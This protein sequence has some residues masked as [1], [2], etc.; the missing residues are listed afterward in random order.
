MTISFTYAAAQP[1]PFSDPDIPPELEQ[2]L[3]RHRE[4]LSRLIRSLRLAG[5]SESHIEESVSILVASYKDELLRTI[6]RMMA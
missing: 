5:V 4:H 2:S 1:D 6:K 3:L